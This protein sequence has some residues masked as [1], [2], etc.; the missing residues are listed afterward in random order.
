MVIGIS[1]KIGCGKSY[2]AHKF[3]MKYPEYFR[4][5]FGDILKREC[6]YLYGYPL[7]WNY[8]SEG[9]KKIMSHLKLPRFSMTVR[10]ILQWHGTDYRR[11]NNPDYWIEEMECALKTKTTKNIIIDD[12]RF[13]NEANFIK[14]RNGLLIRINPYPEWK[15]GEFADH[16]SET[17][18]DDYTDFDLILSPKFGE[19]EKCIPIIERAIEK[20]KEK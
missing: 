17:D 11:K 15:P 6:S 13:K 12:V 8:N 9:K 7:E 3:I 16:A 14:S 10:E 4:V 5:G 19:L 20:R 2:L 18:L 1:G